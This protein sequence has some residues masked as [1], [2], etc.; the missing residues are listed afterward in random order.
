MG[1]VVEDDVLEVMEAVMG[2][3]FE[4]EGF[5]VAAA[6]VAA[7]DLRRGDEPLGA[8]TAP[9]TRFGIE[10]QDLGEAVAGDRV[11]GVL[12]R[13]RRRRGRSRNQR[14]PR[15]L[16]RSDLD[17]LT[18]FAK[19]Y[20]ARGLVWAFVEDGEPGGRRCEVPHRGEGRRQGALA[21]RDGDVL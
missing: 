1:F 2:A 13:A 12:G 21:R 17:A 7:T 14:R 8:R 9:T 20:G 15:E 5:D 10:L 11:Q 19:Q 3:V 18:E 16:A 6:A 4:R